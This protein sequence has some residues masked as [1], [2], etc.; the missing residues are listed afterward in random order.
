M[1]CVLCS[2]FCVLCSVFGVRCSVL[3]QR[4]TEAAAGKQAPVVAENLLADLGKGDSR[5]GI[6]TAVWA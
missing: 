3:N 1:F 5:L 4:Q 2:V 6:I